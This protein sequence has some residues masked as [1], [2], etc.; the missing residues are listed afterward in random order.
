MGK[1]N[2]LLDRLRNECT[3]ASHKR[4][5]EAVLMKEVLRFGIVSMRTYKE[6]YKAGSR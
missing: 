6:R 5:S 3:V 4:K 2:R 1:K